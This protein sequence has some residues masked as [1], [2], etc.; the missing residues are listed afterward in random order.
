MSTMP[1]R[2][3]KRPDAQAVMRRA[4]ILAHIFVKAASTPPAVHLKQWMTAWSPEDKQKCLDEFK[5]RFATQESKLKE[6]GLWD[7]MV[8]EERVFMQAGP[9]ETTDRHQVDASW[10]VESIMC[11]QWALGRLDRFPHYDEQVHP[12]TV[13]F[14]PGVRAHALIGQATLR[15]A[16]EIDRQR[17]L[18]EAWHWRARTHRLLKENKIPPVLENGLTMADVIRLSAGEAARSGGFDF[19]LAED[20][21]V[22]GKPFREISDEEFDS[23]MSICGERHKALNWLCGYAPGNQW[24]KTPTHT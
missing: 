1:D 15:P 21:I 23:V 20:Y 16:A 7:H 10:S 12:E 11:L 6:A 2:N 9:L 13:K 18:A 22:F 24:N 3:G 4:I 14:E 8:E 19:P 5:D 17:D